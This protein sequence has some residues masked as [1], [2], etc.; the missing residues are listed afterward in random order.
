MAINKKDLIKEFVKFINDISFDNLTQNN[1]E[2][3]QIDNM[4][5]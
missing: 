4:N 3:K 2:T 1:R 5:R